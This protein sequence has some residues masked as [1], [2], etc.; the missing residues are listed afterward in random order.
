MV[1]VLGPILAA[2]FAPSLPQIGMA[3]LQQQTTRRGHHSLRIKVLLGSRD[4]F[5][6]FFLS[7][8]GDNNYTRK[9]DW[10]V[11]RL[12]S[13]LISLLTHTQQAQ[14]LHVLGQLPGIILFIIYAEISPTT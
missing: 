14:A 4:F 1:T 12:A 6:L 7:K 8:G 9:L 11:T 2:F 3:N 5:F 13:P 10:G